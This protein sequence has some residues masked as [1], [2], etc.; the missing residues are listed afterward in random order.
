MTTHRSSLILA[1]VTIL[2]LVG[3]AALLTPA[4]AA[5]QCGSQA[6]SCKACHETQGQFP[7]NAEG[8]W[9]VSHAFGDF[10]QFCHAGNVQSMEAEIAHM[11]MVAP[12]AD[13]MTSCSAC[14]AEE[15]YDLAVVYGTVLGVE[16]S[17]D[18][19]AAADEG[20]PAQAALVAAVDPPPAPAPGLGA[21]E[22]DCTGVIDYNALYDATVPQPINKGN[23]ILGLLNAGI[24]FGGGGYVVWN[25]RRKRSL[26]SAAAQP[27]KATP[28]VSDPQVLLATIEKLD[29]AG[30]RGLERLLADPAAAS[31]MFQRLA[32]L[33]PELVRT[34]RGLDRETRAL[35]LAV[36]ND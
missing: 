9:H 17:Q 31:D 4:P 25:E 19:S 34:L 20:A 22:D 15:T 1:A 26:P 35:L 33:D 24:V 12:L 6:S 30:Q 13:P 8:D 10:C 11:G 23:L 7:V 14:H 3:L 29:P 21:I 36:V 28:S 32:S 5:A 27:P 18:D 16:I 2:I